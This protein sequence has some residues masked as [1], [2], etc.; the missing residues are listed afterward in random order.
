[1][2]KAQRA[3]SR[4]CFPGTVGAPG[5]NWMA[6][7]PRLEAGPG[8]TAVSSGGL[9]GMAGSEQEGTA[10]QTLP[11]PRPGPWDPPAWGS[12]RPRPPKWPWNTESRPSCAAQ[13]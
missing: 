9:E 5:E 7:R 12:G 2:C 6:G 4:W 8:W 10:P 11:N 1:M 3:E 13:T